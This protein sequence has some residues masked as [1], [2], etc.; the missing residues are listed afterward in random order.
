MIDV[1]SHLEGFASMKE[2]PNYYKVLANIGAFAKNEETKLLVAVSTKNEL[3][4]GVVYFSDMKFYGSG[5]IATT[6]TNASGIRLLA[7]NL[8]ARGKGLSYDFSSTDSIVGAFHR[9]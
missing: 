6:I 1:Y 2:Q 7:V 4:G 9:S 8:N 3:L 5:A